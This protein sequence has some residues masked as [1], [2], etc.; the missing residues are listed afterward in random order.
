[1]SFKIDNFLEKYQIDS[2]IF[3]VLFLQALGF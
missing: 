3:F 2:K 1:M